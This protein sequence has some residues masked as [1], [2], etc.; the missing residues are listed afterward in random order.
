MLD[1]INDEIYDPKVFAKLDMNEAYTQI[2][3]EE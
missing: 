2:K 1:L 3:V